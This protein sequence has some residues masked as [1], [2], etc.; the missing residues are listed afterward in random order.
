M[1][2]GYVADSNNEELRCA[3][4]SQ[5]GNILSAHILSYYSR[6]IPCGEEIRCFLRSCTLDIRTLDEI[7]AKQSLVG[8]YNKRVALLVEWRPLWLFQFGFRCS[9]SEL[10]YPMPRDHRQR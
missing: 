10:S 6:K 8:L 3:I 1:F 9:K 4:E 7:E 2:D 5:L